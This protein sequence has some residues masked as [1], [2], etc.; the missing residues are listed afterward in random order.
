MAAPKHL[1][2]INK[3]IP[4]QAWSIICARIAQVESMLEDNRVLT[5]NLPLLSSQKTDDKIQYGVVDSLF[6]VDRK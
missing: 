3:A 2:S 4:S 1:H 5:V 6:T